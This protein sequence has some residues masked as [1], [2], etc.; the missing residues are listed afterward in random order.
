MRAA[1]VLSDVNREMHQRAARLRAA[2]TAVPA[3][4]TAPGLAM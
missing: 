2:P 1:S 3:V 4:Q